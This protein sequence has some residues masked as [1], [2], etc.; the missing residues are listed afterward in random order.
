MHPIKYIVLLL[1]LF[2]SCTPKDKFDWNAGFSA[3]KFYGAGGPMVDFFYQEMA[4]KD[5]CLVLSLPWIL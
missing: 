3:P 2:Q 5:N 4:I 1:I